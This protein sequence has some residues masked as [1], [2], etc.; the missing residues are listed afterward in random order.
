M[1]EFQADLQARDD[2]MDCVEEAIFNNAVTIEHGL[3]DGISGVRIPAEGQIS[4]AHQEHA[5][6]MEQALEDLRRQPSSNVGCTE[7]FP[8]RDKRKEKELQPMSD[9]KQKAEDDN[10]LDRS[11]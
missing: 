11:P 6:S 1:S 10:A 4:E 8:A 5:R 2:R 7:N 9:E 3:R